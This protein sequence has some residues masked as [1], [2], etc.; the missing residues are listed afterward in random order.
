MRIRAFEDAPRHQNSMT[1]SSPAVPGYLR[2]P[3]HR[4]MLPAI[5]L[6]KR[7]AILV[8]FLLYK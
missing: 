7:A 3:M 4:S 6:T 2:T 1:R 5:G 8:C